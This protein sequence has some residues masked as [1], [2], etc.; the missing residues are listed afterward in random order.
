[1]LYLVDHGEVQAK[2]DLVNRAHEAFDFRNNP[3]MKLIG[4]DRQFASDAEIEQNLNEAFSRGW[5]L[6][7]EPL[8]ITREGK[9]H[10][11]RQSKHH[12]SRATGTMV[13]P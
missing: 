5:L 7:Q 1:M 9:E 10:L 13:S 6:D 3:W 8:V 12:R 2:G 4:L 11:A